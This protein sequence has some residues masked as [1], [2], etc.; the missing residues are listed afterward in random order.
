MIDPGDKVLVGVSGGKDSLLLAHALGMYRMLRHQDFTLEAVMLTTGVEKPDTSA[1]ERFCEERDIPLRVR[2]TDLY[3]ILFEIR[4]EENPCALCA[5][6]RRAMLCDAC[7][8]VGANKLALGHHRDDAIE[9]LLMSLIYEGRLHTFHPKTYMSRSDLTVIR[10]LVYMPEKDII[11]M[12]RVLD[13]PILEYKCPADGH[14]TR[15]EIKDL[16]K[17]LTKRWPSLPDRMLSAL[18]NEDQYGLW[19]HD[20]EIPPKTGGSP[21]TESQPTE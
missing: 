10:P 11:H 5:K 7:K 17:D 1:I 18:K 2:H 16:I 15:Q 14:T 4:K 19:W 13:L 6:M 3:Q 20:E 8:D 9:T 12:Q 21:V